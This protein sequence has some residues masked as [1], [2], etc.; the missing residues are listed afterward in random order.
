MKTLLISL[1]IITLCLCLC[2]CSKTE[3][4]AIDVNVLTV[5]S[6]ILEGNLI[7]HFLSGSSGKIRSD[8]I[9]VGV[10]FVINDNLFLEDLSLSH[11]QLAYYK[12]KNTLPLRIKI[13]YCPIHDGTSRIVFT[14]NG[15]YINQRKISV[16]LAEELIAYL[17]KEK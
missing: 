7:S 14:L 5:N 4:V 13:Y 17:R 12:N 8:V 2:G 15:Y 11:A 16:K 9:K 6:E 1:C 3:T 10:Q